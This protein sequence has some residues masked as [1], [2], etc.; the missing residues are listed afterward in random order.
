MMLAILED[1]KFKGAIGLHTQVELLWPRGCRGF[2]VELLLCF[3][4]CLIFPH[5][6]YDLVHLQQACLWQPLPSLLMWC[7]ET[8]MRLE[9]AEQPKSES[10][11][12]VH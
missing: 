12:S 6:A 2:V 9:L 10:G 8:H 1:S 7:L 5:Q 3:V 11:T 4:S